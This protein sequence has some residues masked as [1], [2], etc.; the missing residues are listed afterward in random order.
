MFAVGLGLKKQ[1]RTSRVWTTA[2]SV[3]VL[4]RGRGVLVAG[5]SASTWTLVKKPRILT[6]GI[7]ISAHGSISNANIAS[8]VKAFSARNTNTASEYGIAMDTFYFDVSR[9]ADWIWRNRNTP[10]Y[11][12]WVDLTSRNP[13]STN[14][15]LSD[16]AAW[17][18]CT[19]LESKGLIKSMEVTKA[20]RTIR[21]FKIDLSDPRAWNDARKEPFWW[22]RW[23][24]HP[25]C[26]A[27]R[28]F[29]LFA[30]WTL[31]VGLAVSLTHGIK[32]W[33][34]LFWPA[35]SP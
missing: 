30:L 19:V 18:V 17:N 8:L 29:W 32:R 4:F 33:I 22:R 13:D 27:A 11:W 7:C 2:A 1:R 12:E 3:R 23:L 21:A 6:L 9:A 5:S 28:K 16:A 24:T 31:S 34:D 14:I 25:I 10:Q 35:A 26:W 15:G 20:E